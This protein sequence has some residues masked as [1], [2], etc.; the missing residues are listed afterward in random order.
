MAAFLL[1]FVL[2][3]VVGCGPTPS[4]NPT[5]TS[6]PAA[7]A[8]AGPT[9]TPSPTPTPKS[10]ASDP[11]VATLVRNALYWR[12]ARA[13]LQRQIEGVG[14]PLSGLMLDFNS[15]AGNP[16]FLDRFFPFLKEARPR[17]ASAF[18][19]LTKLN[20]PVGRASKWQLAQAEAWGARVNYFDLTLACYDFARHEVVCTDAEGD[21]ADAA[22]LR[23]QS[24]GREA[25]RLQM[26]FLEWM[27]DEISR[28]PPE[29][30]ELIN[31]ELRSAR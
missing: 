1:V 10:R 3:F 5:P 13:I 24:L 6:A 18:T 27:N 8:T 12:E 31:Q 9:P 30:R 21:A 16:E 26:E 20:P 4:S 2:V 11:Q 29:V 19:E 23:S 7:K 17:T 25:E 28:Y 14:R 15:Q 22:L